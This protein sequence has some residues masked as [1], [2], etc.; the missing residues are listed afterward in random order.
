MKLYFHPKW[1][2]QLKS[3]NLKLWEKMFDQID[4]H[5]MQNLFCYHLPIRKQNGGIV[6]HTFISN[7]SSKTL[8]LNVPK[9]S[10]QNS[11]ESIA[12]A[13]F[14]YSLEIPAQSVMPW[15]FV[16]QPD[17]LLKSEPLHGNLQLI[18]L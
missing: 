10:Y 12:V 7:T 15:S 5:D 8:Y 2:S 14:D 3:N 18:T 6:V 11:K 4:P 17:T 9:I 1:Q 16:F 13:Q